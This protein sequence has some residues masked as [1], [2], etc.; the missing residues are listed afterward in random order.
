[1]EKYAEHFLPG[2]AIDILSTLP[3]SHVAYSASQLEDKL[4]EA[5]FAMFNWVHQPTLSTLDAETKKTERNERTL[6]YLGRMY[7][8][9]LEGKEGSKETGWRIRRAL[10]MGVGDNHSISLKAL[11]HGARADAPR[12]I[13][14]G[15]DRDISSYDKKDHIPYMAFNPFN[16][17]NLRY[18]MDRTMIADLIFLPVEGDIRRSLTGFWDHNSVIKN[19]Q[20]MKNSWVRGR[21]TDK[22]TMLID[23]TNIGRAGS[24][25]TRTGDIGSHSS[26]R[27]Y[28]SYEGY[29]VGKGKDHDILKTWKN[30]ENIGTEVLID[31]IDRIGDL[32]N[33]FYTNTPDGEAMRR[34]LVD[35][36]YRRYFKA[37]G[38]DPA[39]VSQAEVDNK[40]SELER[41][42]D[43]KDELKKGYKKFY[44]Q[45]VVR[46]MRQRIPTKFL[47]YERN[48]EVVGRKRAWEEIKDIVVKDTAGLQD[49]KA[50]RQ[51][52][53]DLIA[54]EVKERAEVTVKM[55]E[56]VESKR[57]LNGHLSLEAA[58]RLHENDIGYEL[59]EDKLRTYLTEMNITGER[60]DNA[61]RVLNGIYEFTENPKTETD[62]TPYLDKFASKYENN[63]FPFAMGVEELERSLL[64]QRASG[65]RTPARA[66]MDIANVEE[67]VSNTF[68]DYWLKLKDVA[69][70]GKQDFSELVHAIETAKD[71][72]EIDIGPDYAEKFSH[73]MAA[74][75]ISYFKKDT[76]GRNLITRTLL[77][78]SNRKYSIAAEFAGTYRGIWE[79]N[80]NDVAD[81]VNTLE[82]RSILPKDPYEAGHPPHYEEKNIRILNPFTK[83]P[84]ATLPFK[85]KF[86]KPDREWYGAK[87]REDFGATNWHIVLEY[88]NK[89]VPIV[90]G[91]VLFQYIKEA[92]EEAQGKNQ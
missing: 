92:I 4:L 33:Q 11:E 84:I 8:K 61:V 37:R 30:V 85:A 21:D 54:A 52:V 60:A 40:F 17:Y 26:W 91:F 51:A 6:E 80:V 3:D 56:E 76:I 15:Y 65:E 20:E 86:R 41:T 22:H 43:D 18:G 47:R 55:K 53:R 72:L 48:R 29:L 74:V 81:F 68:A 63:M 9:L 19:M 69:S 49:D 59:T 78:G 28:H 44:Y 24:I 67:K 88:I 46:A 45:T 1:M 35:H 23:Y 71:Q 83:K 13:Q 50:Y 42:K 73:H 2:S 16:H 70:N 31:Y 5:D 64:A 12:N 10:A 79:W 57:E 7:P 58:R 38:Q 75:T 34:Q 89:G 32:N 87:L 66:F 36:V 25:Y 39:T 90:L 14:A 27:K 82:A 62:G 77:T